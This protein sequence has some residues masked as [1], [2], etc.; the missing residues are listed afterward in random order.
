MLFQW[1]SEKQMSHLAP[2][3]TDLHCSSAVMGL[4]M[5]TEENQ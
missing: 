5:E 2:L 4:E 1:K 3:L